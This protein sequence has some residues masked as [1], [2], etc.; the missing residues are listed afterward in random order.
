MS[1]AV[2]MSVDEQDDRGTSSN[3]ALTSA[4]EIGTTV[5]GMG[6]VG[7]QIGTQFSVSSEIPA[8]AHISTSGAAPIVYYPS[9]TGWNQR[10]KVNQ[11]ERR[12]W[13][14]KLKNMIT[15]LPVTAYMPL[16]LW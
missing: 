9:A 8:N 11:R 4:S 10:R 13:T 15:L 16:K 7:T 2:E 1:T 12:T 6:P 3:P 14:K 5:V